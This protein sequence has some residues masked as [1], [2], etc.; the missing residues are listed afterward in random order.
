MCCSQF[1][2]QSVKRTVDGIRSP[3][4]ALGI[5]KQWA[6]RE[7]VHPPSSDFKCGLRQVDDTGLPLSFCF[8]LR[9]DPSLVL[10][11]NMSSLDSQ[12]FLGPTST[13]PCGDDQI[14]HRLVTHQREQLLVFAG[15]DSS[16]SAVGGRDFQMF[17]GIRNEVSLLHGPFAA[18]F[19]GTQIVPPRGSAK[20]GVAIDPLLNVK[21]LQVGGS[22]VG[23]SSGRGRP[24]ALWALWWGRP[25][26]F[27]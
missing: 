6:D 3:R 24:S 18:A 22:K 13:F 23:P 5:S 27:C 25:P 1:H 2:S 14:P 26:S 8:G 4:A 20:V 17:D 21:W 19:Y 11:I 10:I 16:F 12:R 7:L 9:E 15:C